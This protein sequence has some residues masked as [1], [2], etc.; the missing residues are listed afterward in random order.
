MQGLAQQVVAPATAPGLDP[1]EVARQAIRISKQK[2]TK[3]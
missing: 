1:V 3:K 2:G